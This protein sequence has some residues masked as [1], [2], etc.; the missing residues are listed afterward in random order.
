MA[1]VKT[2]SLWPLTQIGFLKTFDIKVRLNGSFAIQDA[3]TTMAEFKSQSLWPL[4]QID[5]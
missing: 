5:F 4:N 3:N 2:Q 1:E